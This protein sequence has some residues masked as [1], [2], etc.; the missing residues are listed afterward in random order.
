MEYF[1]KRN[2]LTKLN[3]S[4]V[5]LSEYFLS[6]SLNFILKKNKH[7][8]VR[9]VPNRPLQS[10]VEYD[11]AI[12]QAQ[13]VR[14]VLKLQSKMERFSSSLDLKDGERKKEEGRE[15]AENKKKRRGKKRWR[16]V[17]IKRGIGF[18]LGTKKKTRKGSFFFN[19][20]KERG[21]GAMK[22]WLA[23]GEGVVAVGN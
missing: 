1:L 20:T 21:K 7:L 17:L 22:G 10:E 5:C 13:I 16:R 19:L 12:F 23:T 18:T 9:I 8:E 14:T 11:P 2:W 3:Y 4:T 6:S 15:R